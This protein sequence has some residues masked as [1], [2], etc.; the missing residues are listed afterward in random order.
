MVLTISIVKQT[1]I[2][3]MKRI[4]ADI[5]FDASYPTDGEPLTP[6]DLG[7][8]SI[9][10]LN[11]SPKLGYMFEYDY[12][13]EKLKAFMPFKTHTPTGTNNGPA[14]TGSE[15]ATHQH[16]AKTAG[17]PAGTNDTPAF[18]GSELGTHQHPVITAGT[19]AGTNAVSVV[20]PEFAGPDVEGIT[21]PTIALTHN[22]NPASN[23]LAAGLYIIEAQGQGTKNIGRLE[24]T[25]NG[26]T[27]ISGET[28]NGS[29]YA[30]AASV[31]FFVK[32]NDT[33]GGLPIY[34]NEASSDQLEFVSPNEI[35]AY[36]VMPFEMAAA[37]V[38][39]AVAVKVHHNAAA[40]DGKP[41]YFDDN[42]GA[43]AQLA[44]VDTGAAGGTIP[45][46][47]VTVLTQ[48]FGD[49]TPGELGEAAAQLFSG[50][51]MS[52][53]QHAAITAGTPAGSVAAPVFTGSELAT[54]QHDAITAGT[55][56]GTN[57][58]PTLTG[59]EITQ[60]EGEEVDNTDD[61]SGITGVRII[62]D[63]R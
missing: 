28:A 11:A 36:I 42:G 20:S 59:T 6:D 16:A 54:H 63:G 10:F 30:V 37:G 58:A 41:L 43:D 25:T 31:R 39:A 22:A 35:D 61:L 33:P 15:L 45:A 48:F 53:H 13:N 49:R 55:P 44:F 2:G 4:V 24:S 1:F 19:P 12:T 46:A 50:A 26:N 14:F 52:T 40:A 29:I 34:I 32:D 7:L 21:K 51:E 17:T 18:T 56:A 3:D 8:Y 62:A 57:A 23:L 9:D 5:A 27:S 47:D 38:V 60:S